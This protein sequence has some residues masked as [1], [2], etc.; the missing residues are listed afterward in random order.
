MSLCFDES[1]KRLAPLMANDP[2]L[3]G[4]VKAL[5]AKLASDPGFFAQLD[6]AKT[7]DDVARIVAAHGIQLSPAEVPVSEEE[8]E[9]GVH[10]FSTPTPTPA[11]THG[12]GCQTSYNHAC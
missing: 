7:R 4:K 3:E 12:W 5:R 11:T 1:E 9:G 10:A 2:A 8:L 6:A